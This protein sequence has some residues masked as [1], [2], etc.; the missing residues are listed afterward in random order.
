MSQA[1][2]VKGN[3]CPE[4]NGLISIT[5]LCI[6]DIAT[7]HNIR[8]RQKPSGIESNTFGRANT[9]GRNGTADRIFRTGTHNWIG[10]DIVYCR[11]T[12]QGINGQEKQLMYIENCR[13]GD[14]VFSYG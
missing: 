13:K 14:P 3:P 10:S 11:H 2:G 9:G 1:G 8:H 4:Q 7:T 6:I 12:D 5:C